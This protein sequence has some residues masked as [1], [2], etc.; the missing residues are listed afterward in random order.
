MILN[1]ALGLLTISCAGGYFV[2]LSIRRDNWR[3]EERKWEDRI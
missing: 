2:Y 1:V 3:Q